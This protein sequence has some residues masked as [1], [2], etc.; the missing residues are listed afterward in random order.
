MPEVSF[1]EGLLLRIHTNKITPLPPNHSPCLSFRFQLLHERF[2][3]PLSCL[4]LE[5][6]EFFSS[7]SKSLFTLIIPL[8]FPGLSPTATG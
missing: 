4:H 3:L 7:F 5:L 6:Q 2:Y 8:A 1:A